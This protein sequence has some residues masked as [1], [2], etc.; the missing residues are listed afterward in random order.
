VKVAMPPGRR[1]LPQVVVAVAVLMCSVVTAAGCSAST[2]QRVVGDFISARIAGND[3]KAAKLTV[4][5]TLEGYVG[6]E[7]F[8][9]ASGVSFKLEPAQ[10]EADRAVVMVQFTWDDKS[11][12]LPYVTRR[13]G[14]KWKVALEESEEMW[15]PGIDMNQ[16][17]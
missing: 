17:P 7:P 1:R 16:G 5:E 8:L 3:E 13:V 15:L 11:V 12:D 4:E 9:Y 2:P 10:S 14:T 6:G